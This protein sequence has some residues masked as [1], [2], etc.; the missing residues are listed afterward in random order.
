M[1]KTHLICVAV[2]LAVGTLLLAIVL[3]TWL[4]MGLIEPVTVAGN[5]MAP[6]LNGPHYSARCPR[7]GQTVRVGAEFVPPSRV[8]A[9]PRCENQPID[10]SAASLH[11]GDRLWI[12]RT[13]LPRRMPRRWEVVVF[14]CPNDGS[15]LCVKRI[16]GLPG[17]TV[18]LRDGD[19]WIN[20]RVAA[21]SLAEQRVMRQLVY[22]AGGLQ[23]RWKAEKAAGWR[24]RR[25]AW[26]YA[27]D[28]ASA[29]SWI[30]YPHTS[31]RPVT[32]DFSY[33]ASLSRQL[34]LVHDMMLSVRLCIDQSLSPST[35]SNLQERKSRLALEVRY[36][37]RPLVIELV[38]H[39]GLVQ[40]REGD[41]RLKSVE[42]SSQS[43]DRLRWGTVL[44][45]VST[46]D[47]Q[48]LLAVDGR[49]E[50][51]YSLTG[52]RQSPGTTRPFAIGAAGG[53]ITLSELTLWRD[54]YYSKKAVGMPR[55]EGTAQRRLGRDEFFVL[56][57]NSPISLDS[58]TWGPVSARLL[59]GAPLF[60][61]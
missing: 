50:L 22:R 52:D 24:W 31:K 54:V 17:E 7:C 57:D 28:G 19:L 40:L 39:R 47:R 44:L 36:D 42:L 29:W 3:R 11:R 49:V 21:K 14:R 51:R 46:F 55:I 23:P 48:L 61:R 1:S 2:H 43:R 9:C 10:F 27:P 34:N 41:V 15:Q 16:V 4:V 38:I 13:S 58:R 37:E 5:S 59:L 6:T 18:E 25:E 53:A 20:G 35:D 30:R 60:V 8:V 12:D 45:E 56:G 32:D 26:Q 33:N